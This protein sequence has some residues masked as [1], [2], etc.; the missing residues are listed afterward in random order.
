M[1]RRGDYAGAAGVKPHCLVAGLACALAVLPAVAADSS[2]VPSGVGRAL[3]R[4]G[5]GADVPAPQ[6]LPV[7]KAFALTVTAPDA[8]TLAAEF[9]PA[10]GYYLYRDKLEFVLKDTAGVRIKRIELPRGERK[11]DP[12]FGDTYVFTRPVRALVRLERRALAA[13]P[14]TLEVRY[15]GCA[16]A[17]LCY[18]P[19]VRRFELTLARV[20]AGTSGL[21]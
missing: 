11:Q 3:D 7:E 15:Q 14:V 18:P 19:E 2:A 6:F 5:G 17:G 10:A 4:L 8:R 13:E 21:R 9:R 1:D 20:K 12:N 16:E